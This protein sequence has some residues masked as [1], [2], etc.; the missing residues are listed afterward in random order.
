MRSIAVPALL[1]L[2]VSCGLLAGAAHAQD[3]KIIEAFTRAPTY[4]DGKLSPD[5]KYVAFI[6]P[7]EDKS[8]LAV[9]DRVGLKQTGVFNMRGKTRVRDFW[10]VNNHRVVLSVAEQH[11]FRDTPASTGELMA[12]EFD[13]NGNTVL[14]GARSD[15]E[16]TGT[17]IRKKANSTIYADY[18][19]RL[20]GKEDQIIVASTTLDLDVVSSTVDRLDVDSGAR[21]TMA[22]VPLPYPDVLV[23]RDGQARFA[24]GRAPSAFMQTLYRA[25]PN[26]DWQVINDEA[27]SHVLEMPIGFDAGQTVAYLRRQNPTGPDSIV[28][29]DLATRERKEVL[30]DPRVDPA[31]FMYGRDGRTLIAVAFRN[32]RPQWRFLDETLPEA[33]AMKAMARALPDHYLRLA[34]MTDDGSLALVQ[35]VNDTDSGAFYIFDTVKKTAEELMVRQSWIDPAGVAPVRAVDFTT[36]DGLHEQALLTLP[37]GV[38]KPPLVVMPHGG[39]FGIEDLWEADAEDPDAQVLAAHGFA[40][41]RVNFR[42]SGGFGREFQLKGHRQW[43]GTMQDDLTDATQAA[44]AQGLV[45]GGRVCVYGASYGGYAALMAP[46]R[47]PGMYKCVVGYV[48]AYDLV[49]TARGDN[50]TRWAIS[51]QL[52]ADSLG[53]DAAVLAAASP[54]QLAAQVKVPVMLAAAGRDETVAKEQSEHMRDALAAAGNPPDWLM[55]ESEGHGYYTIEHRR[56]FYARLIAFLNKHIG[57]GAH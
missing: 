18:I 51:K 43:G 34:S 20:P 44:I 7:I 42:G 46:V 10:W 14:T 52:V 19:D 49:A 6:V 31:D 26:A 50:K 21:T 53:T 55:F 48:G 41:L 15:E 36:R 5:G 40:V 30:R 3:A 12:M 2:A 4:N 45:D 23:D 8:I 25:G 28:A 38:A 37:K 47:A 13:G 9:F 35:A 32:P 57:S 17:H 33:K 24:M 22:R 56:E 1:S 39:P 16:S 54:V 11:G 29:F 27:T